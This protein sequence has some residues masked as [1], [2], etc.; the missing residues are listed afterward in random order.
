MASKLTKLSRPKSSTSYGKEPY[1]DDLV[2][3]G[4]VGK[5]LTNHYTKKN[6]KRAKAK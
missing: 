3:Q 4:E 5:A 2:R 6:A 1:R